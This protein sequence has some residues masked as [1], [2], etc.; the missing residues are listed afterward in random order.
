MFYAGLDGV[1]FH[2]FAS[3]LIP[4]FAIH[5]IVGRTKY[6][7]NQLC[8]SSVYSIKIPIIVGVLAIPQIIHPIDTIFE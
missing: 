8:M 2:G 6:L 3:I 4:G 7:V 1:I 5:L